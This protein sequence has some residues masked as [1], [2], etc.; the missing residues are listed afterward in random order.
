MVEGIKS[1]ISSSIAIV[2]FITIVEMLIPEGN[3]K[4]YIMVVSGVLV[5][6]VLTLPIVSSIKKNNSFIVPELKV[7]NNYQKEIEEIESKFSN[8]QEKQIKS[9]Y[10]S[11]IEKSIIESIKNIN[12]YSCVK[13][14]CEVDEDTKNFGKIKSIKI[15]LT[16]KGRIG[17]KH[18]IPSDVKQEIIGIIRA[19]Y[20]VETDKITI[21]LLNN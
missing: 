5:V 15:F 12:G 3:T 19:Q 14:K 16:E 8:L 1:W 21:A 7:Q 17:E 9:V 11:R 13:A 4:K 10:A 2:F 6:L 20:Q 18:D